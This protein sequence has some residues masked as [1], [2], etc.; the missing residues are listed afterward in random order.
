MAIKIILV[1]VYVVIMVAIGLRNR[2]KASTVENFV[3]G[4]RKISPWFAA[5]SYGTAFFS[6]VIFVGNAGQFGWRFGTGSQWI[7][8]FGCVVV[9][10]FLPWVI[11]GK[12]TRALS[13]KMNSTTMADYFGTRF[14]CQSLRIAAAAI[15]FVFLIPYTSSIYNGLSALF[16]RCYGIPFY[17]CV[18]GVAILTGI[19][20]VL[21]GYMASSQ[22]DFVQGCIMLLGVGVLVYTLFAHHGG[23]QQTM[24]SLAFV[25][26]DVPGVYASLF[27]PDFRTVFTIAL[28]V[29]L[30]GWAMPQMIHKF[31]VVKDEKAFTIGTTV[32]VVFSFVIGGGCYVVGMLGRLYDNPS[33]YNSDGSVYYDRIVPYIVD[34]LSPAL[35]GL[36]MI[37]V[38]AA[39]MSTLAS[40]VISSSSTIT[41]DLISLFDKNMTEKKKVIWIRSLVVVFIIL[42]AAL[43]IKRPLFIAQLFS[44]AWG[45]IAGSFIGPYTWSLY[46]KKISKAAVWMSFIFGVGFVAVN[47]YAKFMSTTDASALVMIVSLI[48]T[49]IISLFTPAPKKE[50][51]DELFTCFESTEKKEESA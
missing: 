11:L 3:L 31:Y 32:S 34:T 49:P 17:W 39:S 2:Y 5:F 26:A 6:G 30:G 42:S 27:G 13:R 36:V 14:D 24:T 43:S 51:V 18:I 7:G 28:M 10:T 38:L 16:E 48:M 8:V 15:I 22:T 44:L 45:A 21:G 40:L 47:L 4:G 23:F 50:Y 33:F 9:A 1:V 12:R 19:Y 29:G 25:E 35:V 41:L 46:S 37:L 20:V